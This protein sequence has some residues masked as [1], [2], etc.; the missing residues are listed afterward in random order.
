MNK[1]KRVN[2]R[3]TDEEDARLIEAIQGNAF[4]L[5]KVF[6][7][8]A[9]EL[10]RTETSVSLRWYKVLNNL[11]HPK[12]ARGISFV[13]INKKKLLKNSKV[14]TDKS[15]NKPERVKVSLWRKFLKLFTK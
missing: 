13:I 10:G 15:K 7:D 6:K 11:D 8:L 2:K 9:K 1:R 4:N 5:S 14:Y 3:W 12:Y